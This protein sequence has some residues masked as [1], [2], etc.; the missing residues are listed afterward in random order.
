M[1]NKAEHD[2]SLT[3]ELY[4][5]A[6]RLNMLGLHDEGSSVLEKARAL[7]NGKSILSKRTLQKRIDSSELLESLALKLNITFGNRAEISSRS[8]TEQVSVLGLLSQALVEVITLAGGSLDAKEAA[9]LTS[10]RMG[11]SLSWMSYVNTFARAEKILLP[12]NGTGTL[13][14]ASAEKV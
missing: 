14:L 7:E 11:V 9:T 8:V 1:T 3:D 4:Y 6:G 13:Q 2:K 12:L 10:R 5:L